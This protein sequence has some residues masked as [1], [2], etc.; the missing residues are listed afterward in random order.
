MAYQKILYLLNA[1]SDSKFVTREWGI[2]NDRSNRIMM[3]EMRLS[4]TLKIVHHF[5]L[6]I[7]TII[8]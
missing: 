2:V 1:T 6:I 4:I 8:F 7:T 5:T 3:Q